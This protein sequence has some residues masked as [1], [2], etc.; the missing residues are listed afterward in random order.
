MRNGLE[1]EHDGQGGNRI[2]LPA[3]ERTGGLHARKHEV[4]A[5]E[6]PLGIAHGR[7]ERRSVDHA[8]EHSGL[9]HIELVGLLVEKGVGRRLDAERVGTV[10]D[11]IEIHGGDLLLG[12][13]VFELEGRNPLLELGRNELGRADDL[14]AVAH[15]V[16]RKEVLGQLLGD[17][18]TAALR[19]VEHT[20]GFHRHAGQR[21][22]V[23][24]RMAAETDVLG[25]DERRDDGRHLVAVETDVLRGV[26]RKE[27]GILH[28]GTVLNEKRTDDFTVLR[29]DF[30]GEVAARV[31]QLL[32]RRH[33][34]EDTAG[35]EN[36]QGENQGER[37][38]R[39][40]PYP[41]YNLGVDPLF[42]AL[43]H[44]NGIWCEDNQE[45]TI[46]NSQFGIFRLPTQKS[47]GRCR[48]SDSAR[49]TP[50]RHIESLL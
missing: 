1:I 32:E 47:A 36:Q 3:A 42:P 20:H 16:A 33:P 45:F 23:D 26:E 41:S 5:G 4:A 30:G 34:P 27:V 14:A 29:I 17:G 10:L 25:G 38:E 12:V 37:S 24:A 39:H 19:G 22:D 6:R 44:N 31:L 50:E 46:Q 9:L 43:C 21:R 15:R 11:G 28:V 49:N 13:V 7:I 2:V 48:R 35:G 40:D 18:R 8:D